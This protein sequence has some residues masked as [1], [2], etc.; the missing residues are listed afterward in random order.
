MKKLFSKEKGITMLTL[1]LTIVVMIVIMS[2]ITFYVTNSIQA[3]QFQ[4]LK[5]DVREIESKA[6]MYYVQEGVVP[7]YSGEGADKKTRSEIRGNSKCFNPN[8]GDEYAKVNLE[9]LGVVPAYDTTYYINTESLAV[10]AI[11][12]VKLKGTE[13]PRMA[14]DFSKI[15]TNATI[16]SWEKE[17]FERTDIAQCYEYD[18]KGYIVKGYDSAV[19]NGEL[20]IP[21]VQPDGMPVVGITE[22]AFAKMN[23][24]NTKI[25]KIP[26]TIKDVPSNLLGTRGNQVNYIYCDASGLKYDTFS[27]CNLVKEVVLGPSCV[28]PDAGGTKGLFSNNSSLEKVWIETKSLGSRAFYSCRSL[29]LVV[30]NNSIKVIPDYFLAS[31]PS[32]VI[33]IRD[34]YSDVWPNIDS[35]F[36]N[37]PKEIERIG[38]AAFNE[39]RKYASS[40]LDLRGYNNLIYIGQNAFRLFFT[41][42][43]KRIERVKVNDSTKY[44]SNSFPEGADIK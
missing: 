9:L 8:D 11:D 38:N 3:E 15:A 44:Q 31:S 2:V 7:V 6:L 17:C 23:F 18:E 25:V 13:Y 22:N 40:E 43:D 37:F 29:Q 12:P 1:T 5:A 20:I 33:A 34:S 28:I 30:L 27:E 16:P 36:L 24:N 41:N 4:K 26:N 14:S 32:T 39:N 21:A 35:N 42:A 19:K 10:Y